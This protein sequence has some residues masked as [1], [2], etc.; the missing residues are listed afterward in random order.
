MGVQDLIITPFYFFI[1]L[2]A[3]YMIR[4]YV[5]NQDTKPYFIPGLFVKFIGAIALGL[6][7]QFYYGG[8]D[9]F[10]FHTHGSRWI[11]QAFMD[12]PG[13]GLK[14][15]FTEAGDYN[16]QSYKYIS[17]IWQ[18]RD[19]SSW[20]VIKLTAFFDLI[21]FGTYGATALFFSSFSFLGSWALYL[22]FYKLRPNLK[23]HIALAVLFI[24]SVIFWGS[25][26]LKDTITFGAL[27][28]ITYLLF[29]LTIHKKSTFIHIV[30][31]VF[32]SWIILSI[33]IYILLCFLIAASAFMIF[34]Y[35]SFIKKPVI[36]IMAMPLIG[37]VFGG[38]GFFAL[39][40]VSQEDSRYALN[41]IAQ[42]AAV[43][44]YDIRAGWGA[45]L[46]DTSS[47]NLGTLDGSLT[48]FISLAPKGIVVTLFRPFLWEAQ[49]PLM[50]L[51]ALESLM[52]TLLTLN[53]IF[54]IKIRK[55]FDFIQTPI[56]IFCLTF[57][58]IFAFAVGVSTSNFGTL[59]RYKIPVMPFFLTSLIFLLGN[60]K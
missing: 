50:L 59:M 30:S 34:Q 22:A 13:I 40:K 8:G 25:G 38:A 36:K 55:I 31:L 39:Q 11:W 29:E 49:N 52:V 42:T 3:A 6:I 28:L 16:G 46:G 35:T 1:L 14:L 44:A 23:K 12:N 24:P 9:T 58:L 33:K 43:T 53:V 60:K 20:F 37:V 48:S 15:F 56:G 26:I 27:G 5:T 21:T 17:R 32:F 45:R 2:I 18:F 4:P 54:T 51:A 57:T 41:N 19:S 47:Y 7:Y 10:T